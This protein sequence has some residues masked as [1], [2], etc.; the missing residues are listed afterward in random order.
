MTT[1]RYRKVSEW[2]KVKLTLC[3]KFFQWMRN[4]VKLIELNNG[5]GHPNV[6][7][8][9]KAVMIKMKLNVLQIEERWNTFQ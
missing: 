4:W 7:C 3:I 1:L 8:I 2:S 9:D 6:G 5:K